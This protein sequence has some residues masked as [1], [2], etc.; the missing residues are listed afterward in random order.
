MLFSRCPLIRIRYSGLPPPAVVTCRRRLRI[1][2]QRR[3]EAAHNNLV[4]VLNKMR[5]FR[6]WRKHGWP[7]P[8]PLP[9][10][11]A[12]GA[13]HGHL[14]RSE[15]EERCGRSSLPIPTLNSRRVDE[16]G[17]SLKFSKDFVGGDIFLGG[18]RDF[19]LGLFGPTS[20]G[21]IIAGHT[22]AT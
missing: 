1:N 13:G 11:A 10:P 12:G 14:R 8:L 7:W 17:R 3:R 4:I 5:P 22:S 6:W 18:H 20:S 19:L 16:G 2:W 9:A 21:S 15:S